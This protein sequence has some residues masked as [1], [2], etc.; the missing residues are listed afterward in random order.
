[1]GGKIENEMERNL[2][3]SD[4]SLEKSSDFKGILKTKAKEQTDFGFYV[5]Q[6][7]DQVRDRDS[8]GFHQKLFLRSL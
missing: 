3:E 8:V 2:K 1:M 7:N 6:H 4:S 5:F